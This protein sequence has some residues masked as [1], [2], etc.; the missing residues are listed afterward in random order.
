MV[1]ITESSEYD[2]NTCIST[3]QLEWSTLLSDEDSELLL[4]A[5]KKFDSKLQFLI[6]IDKLF[7][8][9]IAAFCE[10]SENP[11]AYVE[12]SKETDKEPEKESA[13]ENSNL[14]SSELYFAD[15]YESRQSASAL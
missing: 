13:P 11:S 12:N 4:K 10:M 5:E 8:E 9:S 14:I 3:T 6:G 7:H 15:K 2:N 1:K